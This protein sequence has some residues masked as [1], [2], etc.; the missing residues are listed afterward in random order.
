M[1]PKVH[2]GLEMAIGGNESGRVGNW[3]KRM[4]VFGEK[5]RRLPSK[6]WKTIW[7]VGRDDPRRAIHALKVGLSLTLV[8]LLYLLEP[9][10]KGIGQNAIWAVMTVVVVFEFTAGQ[11][12]PKI[13]PS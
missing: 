11:F 6:G 8:S 4:H 3:K 13:K 1:V 9:L 7:K 12:L 10:F 5:L 2:V